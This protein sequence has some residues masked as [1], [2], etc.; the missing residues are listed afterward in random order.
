MLTDARDLRNKP[1]SGSLKERYAAA[2]NVK[3][4]EIDNE[5]LY[6]FIDKWM[7][8]PYRANGMDRD[9]VDCSG[10]TT[11]LEKEVFD[12][13]VPRIAKQMAENVKRKYEE[14]LQ[15]GDLVFFDF[16]GQKFSHVGIYL[17]NNKFVHA[18]TSKGVIISDLK[19]PWYYKY[20][21]R[22]G[23]PKNDTAT[24]GGQ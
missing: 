10:F 12:V 15:E 5:K 1:V 8:V 13:S 21:S 24:S 16:S 17:K 6:K 14:D 4:R 20:F 23:S 3:E 2:L 9:G 11:L 18:S 7:G 22:A 19:D